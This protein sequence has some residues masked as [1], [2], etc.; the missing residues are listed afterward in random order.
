M[1]YLTPEQ[2]LFIHARMIEETGGEHGLRNMGILLAAVARPQAI[3]EGQ[4]LYENLYL[5]AG[6]L[7]DSLIRN[8][9]FLDGN[10]RTGI[11]SASLF[12]SSNGV[13]LETTNEEIV[14]FTMDC[15]QSRLSIGE[16]S[17]W[18]KEHSLPRGD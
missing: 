6:A 10:K 17:A 14:H 11:A 5:I 9:T 15:A 1:N 4:E 2:V 12:L 8:H 16:I 13:V 3:F 7:M 18:L